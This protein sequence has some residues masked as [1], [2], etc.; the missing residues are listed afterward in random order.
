[1]ST[2]FC[3]MCDRPRGID[4]ECGCTRRAQR[5]RQE[6]RNLLADALEGALAELDRLGPSASDLAVLEAARTG[7]KFCHRPKPWE[8]P[9]HPGTYA[10]EDLQEAC[11]R[12]GVTCPI[13]TYK[14]TDHHG[15]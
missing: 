5:A 12:L 9:L 10:I 11:A 6:A 8:R 4:G 13:R 15:R 1:V 7:A 2:I 3:G 14:E